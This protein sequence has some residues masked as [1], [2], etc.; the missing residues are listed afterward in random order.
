MTD[1]FK[2]DYIAYDEFG[3]KEIRCM[4]T[5]KVIA[6][7]IERESKKF[8]G[9]TS[10][11]IMRYADYR[12]I[13]FLA[14]DGSISFLIFCDEHKD[15]VV[16]EA[17]AALITEQIR[18]AKVMELKNS[19]K[20]PEFIETVMQNFDRKSIVRKLTDEEVREKFSKSVLQ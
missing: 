9:K 18:R 10:F 5:G 7:R 2:H 8:S 1:N 19:G 4:A 6:S 11:D 14:K 16:G 20:T 12:E 17:E 15:T 3:L 13:P